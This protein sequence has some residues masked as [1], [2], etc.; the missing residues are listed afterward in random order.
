MQIR[1]RDI[2]YNVRYLDVEPSDTIDVLRKKI[3]DKGI[4]S[5]GSF[6]LFSNTRIKR[7]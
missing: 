2:N 3:I 1:I 6:S 4:Q 5:S 7:Q